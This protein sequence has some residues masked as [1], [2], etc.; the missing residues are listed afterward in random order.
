MAYKINEEICKNIGA[1]ENTCPTEAIS[2]K[3]GKRWIDPDK[4]VD[5]GAC[6]SECPVNAI[7]SE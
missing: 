1:C 6:M 5:C 4:C 3:N 7:S 2:E